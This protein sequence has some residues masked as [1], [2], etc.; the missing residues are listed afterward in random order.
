MA[1]ASSRTEALRTPKGILIF[2]PL[3][4]LLFR[5]R[6]CLIPNRLQLAHS[7]AMPSNTARTRMRIL[8][9]P[10]SICQYLARTRRAVSMRDIRDRSRRSTKVRSIGTWVFQ[11]ST[12]LQYERLLH[13]DRAIQPPRG[14]MPRTTLTP[15]RLVR[16]L[17]INL[18]L[19]L[20]INLMPPLRP[21]RMRA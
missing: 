7:N 11:P 18:I 6:A 8:P 2:R 21:V 19:M 14:R 5:H 20:R 17:S 13:R 9:I 10:A 3:P 4:C 15:P 12:L 1:R 16:R